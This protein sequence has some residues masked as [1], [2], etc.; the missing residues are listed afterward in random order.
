MSIDSGGTQILSGLAGNV[1]ITIAEHRGLVLPSQAIVERRTEDL[2]ETAFSTGLAERS[3]RVTAVVFIDDGGKAIMAPVR[4]GPSSMTQTIVEEGL[5]ANQT[6]V[7]GPYKAL[8]R[9]KQG[10]PIV[11]DSATAPSGRPSGGGPPG[12]KPDGAPAES[13]PAAATADRAGSGDAKTGA[14]ERRPS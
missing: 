10:D 13:K 12:G 6:V 11:V 8:E 5:E 1:D 14:S 3:R 4:T 7:T 9:M 2:P